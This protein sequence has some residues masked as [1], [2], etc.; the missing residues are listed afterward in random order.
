MFFVVSANGVPQGAYN[1]TSSQ[2][3]NSKT[4]SQ[5]TLNTDIATAK[6]NGYDLSYVNGTLNKIYEYKVYLDE[7]GQVQMNFVVASTNTDEFVTVNNIFVSY[8]GLSGFV[9][10]KTEIE[11]VT[12]TIFVGV[13]TNIEYKGEVPTKDIIK[14]ENVEVETTPIYTKITQYE[15]VLDLSASITDTDGNGELSN[16][17][18]LEDIPNGVTIKGYEANEDG[19][20][21]VEIG[22]DGKA[23]LTL[24]SDSLLNDTD[25][26]SIKANITATDGTQFSDIKVN[27]DEKEESSQS[28]TFDGEGDIDLTSIIGQY[29]VNYIDLENGKANDIKLDFDEILADDK[30]IYIKGDDKDSISLNSDLWK[31]AEATNVDGVKY[32]VYTGTNSAAN[33]T[34]KLLIDDDIQINHDI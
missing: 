32:N 20:Y 10:T 5:T 30:E 34:I 11:K 2:D 23:Q 18:T 31:E 1:Y 7:N 9:Q 4:P 22:E 15:Y 33:S 27:I 24:I 26:E 25:K 13:P 28:T 21:T 17:I 8:E 14:Y 16:I 6:T 19:T 3:Y 12:E 29:K